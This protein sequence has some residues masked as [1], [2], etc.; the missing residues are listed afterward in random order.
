MKYGMLGVI[1]VGILMG[2]LWNIANSYISRYQKSNSLNILIPIFLLSLLFVS[3]R[4][5]T[6]GRFYP[7]LFI[8]LFFYLNRIKLKVKLNNHTTF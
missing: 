3:I 4:D 8:V 5:F 7:F 6:A 1:Q 2:V